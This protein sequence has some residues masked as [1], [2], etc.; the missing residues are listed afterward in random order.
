MTS[1]SCLTCDFSKFSDASSYRLHYTSEWHRYNL[2]RSLAQLSPL[3]FDAFITR[4]PEAAAQDNFVATKLTKLSLSPQPS[5]P[6]TVATSAAFQ[7]VT[8]RYAASKKES[9]CFVIILLRVF[10]TVS[11]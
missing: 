2:K 11:P 3:A 10:C 8:C 9:I 6:S 1:F 4:Y 5:T 7:C